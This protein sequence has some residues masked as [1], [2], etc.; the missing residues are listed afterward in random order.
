MVGRHN[1][2]DLS[3]ME[4]RN[5]GKWGV[6]VSEIG[7]GSW[8][9][10][11]STAGYDQAPKIIERAHELGVNFFDTAD[12]YA[13]GEAE[14]VLGKTLSQFRRESYVIATKLFYPRGD[15]PNDGGLS[16]KHIVEQCNTSL[17]RLGVEYIDL[18]QCHGYDDSTPLEE[19]LRAFE[20]L[21]RQGKILYMG[22][23]NWKTNHIADATNLIRSLSLRP[24]VSNQPYYNMLDPWIEREMIPLCEREGIGQVVFCPLSEGVL[25]GKYK[26][27]EPYPA[28]SRA[29][30]SGQN[31]YM[32]S[33]G[34]MDQIKLQ[35]VQQLIPIAQEIGLTMP[36]LALAWC[37]RQK[38]VSAVI[39]G[40][41]RPS[42]IEDN[43]GA[44]GKTL[45]AEVLAKIDTV[46]GR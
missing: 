39:T 11:S 34:E 14:S 29:A 32:V 45:S 15:G 13:G 7:L 44:S 24:I 16:R 5:L 35:R 37:L 36:Q 2:K 20:D 18:L 12:G 31:I 26:P 1:K 9:N 27:G 33:N 8:M 4:Y 28:G 25:T 10:F 17:K 19:T 42:Q 23:S 41:S 40:A 21:V 46:F 30:D 22:I 38:N 6:K 43:V 3:S